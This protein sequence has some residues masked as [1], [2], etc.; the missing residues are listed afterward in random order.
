MA[1]INLLPWRDDLRAE[2]QKQFIAVLVAVAAAS[3]LAAFL[4][5]GSINAAIENQNAR[6]ELLN[7]E[8]SGLSKQVKEI[9]E[10]KKRRAELLSRM[11]VIQSLQGE[12]PVIVRYFDELV[13]VIPEDVY[14][15]SLSKVGN[16][17]S[18]GGVATSTVRVS[19]LMRNIDESDWFSAPNL[20]SVN[21]ASKYGKEASEFKLAF[22]AVKAS[23]AKGK[24]GK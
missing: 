23:A 1:N 9:Q 11:K 12:R 14:I 20:S 22:N 5:V 6:N 4:W 16:S 13:R 2:K 19:T 8:I 15:L 17:I 7:Q 21:A 24:G 3:A 10:L 18:I